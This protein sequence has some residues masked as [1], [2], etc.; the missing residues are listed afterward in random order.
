[1]P[2]PLQIAH[3]YPVVRAQ[4]GDVQG[5]FMIDT[6][7]PWGLLPNSARVKMPD[8]SYVLTGT[9]GS[10]Q[11]FDVSRA[12]HM[13]TL[14]IHGQSWEQVRNV[15]AADRSFIEQGTGKGLYLGFIGANFLQ[16]TALAADHARRVAIL[17]RLH[18]DAG[19]PRVALPAGQM[20][21]YDAFLGV[22]TNAPSYDWHLTN[23]RNYLHLSPDPRRPKSSTTTVPGATPCDS[24]HP[25]CSCASDAG[26]HRPWHQLL[27]V[28]AV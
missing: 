4:V 24:C 14:R 21:V 13:P 17:Q 5:V 6:G 16:D 25:S 18:P 3:G 23:L 2:W 26:C 9:A 12:T 15:H 11:K 28:Q 10:G 1:M 22:I 19:A 8:T 27:Q 7:T 20:K